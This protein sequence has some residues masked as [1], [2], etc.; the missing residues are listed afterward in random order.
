MF[1]S[2]RKKTHMVYLLL[3]WRVST[4]H[5]GNAPCLVSLSEFASSLVIT[6]AITA[7][8]IYIYITYLVVPFLFVDAT[9]HLGCPLQQSIGF[10]VEN[11]QSFE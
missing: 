9:W 3:V 6:V 5:I 11:D 1:H 7:C 4:E 10:P 2:L 8:R